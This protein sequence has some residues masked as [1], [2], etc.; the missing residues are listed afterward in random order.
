MIDGALLDAFVNF[1]YIV[2]IV[3]V[4]AISQHLLMSSGVE[5]VKLRRR[6]GTPYTRV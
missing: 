6:L 1:K 5:R 4:N 3:A 2:V